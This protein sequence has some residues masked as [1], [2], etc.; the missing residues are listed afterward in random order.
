MSNILK[1]V[2]VY[3]FV[4]KVLFAERLKELRK[5]KNLLQSE[6]AKAL[7]TTQRK[8][9]YWETEKI[10]PDLTSLWKLS[11]YFEVSVDYLIGKSDY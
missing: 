10:E 5:E 3:N 1:T 11:E 2:C 9:S 7:N 4:M 8:V 6:L